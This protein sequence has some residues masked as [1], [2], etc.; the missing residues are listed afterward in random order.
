KLLQNDSWHL[1][2]RL[3][4]QA[5]QTPM[6]DFNVQ[7]LTLS[8]GNAA[9]QSADLL[10]SGEQDNWIRGLDVSKPRTAAEKAVGLLV[11]DVKSVEQGR[12]LENPSGRVVLEAST[13]GMFLKEIAASHLGICSGD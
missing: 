10:H 2:A 7:L 11:D 1:I 4:A 5:F 6:W 8:R 13:N 12:Q 9:G 3:G